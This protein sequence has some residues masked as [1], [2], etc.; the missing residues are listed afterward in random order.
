M[1][2]YKFGGRTVLN[3]RE[4]NPAWLADPCQYPSLNRSSSS[5][6]EPRATATF[7]THNPS[8]RRIS[9]GDYLVDR[10]GEDQE[11]TMPLPSAAQKTDLVMQLIYAN[12]P[13]EIARSFLDHYDE[14]YG[15]FANFK[16]PAGTSKNGT[17]AGWTDRTSV[18]VGEWIYVR[19]PQVVTTHPGYST[20]TIQL[21]NLEPDT[22]SSTS[23]E[24]GGSDGGDPGSGD[25]GSGDPGSG[26]SNQGPQ[27]PPTPS[28]G[29]GDPALPTRSQ[30]AY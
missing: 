5:T 30:R 13:D 15:E 14:A 4:D 1:L 3:E 2:A 24:E 21:L 9:Y 23:K 28:P 25:P 26:D 17:F 8:R 11:I 10:Y 22:S 18:L 20:T 7:P 6:P 16:I 27:V 12:R 19:P 29:P